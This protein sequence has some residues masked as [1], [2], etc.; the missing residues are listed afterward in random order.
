MYRQSW[1]SVYT[2]SDI[3]AVRYYMG[4]LSPIELKAIFMRFWGPCTIAQVAS[5]LRLSW[6]DTDRLIDR[7]LARLKVRCI[8][9][10][11]P[12]FHCGF[13]SVLAAGPC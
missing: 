7:T 8:R 1:V 13:T 9:D 5:E 4:D 12:Y 2:Q 3:E 6:D 10:G 11:V